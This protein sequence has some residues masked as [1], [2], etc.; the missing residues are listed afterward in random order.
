M[1]WMRIAIGVGGGGMLAGVAGMVVWI[2][3][4]SNYFGVAVALASAGFLTLVACVLTRVFGS[5]HGSQDDAF[6]RGREMGYDAGFLEGHR[7]ARPV[8]VPMRA[9][10][11]DP[12][13][14]PGEV[15]QVSELDTSSTMP[16]WGRDTMPVRGRGTSRDARDRV[17]TWVRAQRIPLLA[18]ALCLAMLGVLVAN[19]AVPTPIPTEAVQQSPG[20]QPDRAVPPSADT[21]ALVSKP[22]HSAWTVAV[23]ADGTLA[24]PAVSGLSPVGPSAAG[25]APVVVAVDAA[26]VQPVASASSLPGVAVMAPATVYLPAAPSS[27]PTPAVVPVVPVVAAPAVPVVDTRTIA[28]I[29]ADNAAAAAAETARVAAE[30]AAQTAATAA[31]A[32]EATRLQALADAYAVAHPGG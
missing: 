21:P 4:R 16:L 19:A 29:T 24:V 10:D 32:A 26:A 6:R 22:G 30:A 14:P 3:E 27:V 1:P 5:S 12:E 20:L 13:T 11:P 2:D 8:V 15:G 31:A 28:Q 17:V 18:G 23:G 25:V 9:V 7:T